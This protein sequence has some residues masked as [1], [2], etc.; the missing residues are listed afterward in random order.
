MKGEK[1]MNPNFSEYELDLIKIALSNWHC[2]VTLE[3][4]KTQNTDLLNVSKDLYDL[5]RKIEGL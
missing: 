1:T 4:L 3:S 5:I 2:V